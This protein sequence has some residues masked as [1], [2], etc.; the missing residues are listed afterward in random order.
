VPKVTAPSTTVTG[1]TISVFSAIQ[2]A[3]PAPSLAP[4]STARFYLSTDQTLDLG[5]DVLLGSRAVP[6]LTAGAFSN[7]SMTLTIPANTSEG[8]FFILVTADALNVV[9]E[10]NEGNNVGV[11]N[12]VTV[13]RPD[14]RVTAA[15]VTPAAVSSRGTVTVTNT[16]TNV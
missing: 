6:A 12:A 9:V 5:T 13:S 7:A 10:S 11:S 2:N 3:G 15:S 8:A 1:G 16:I 4:A 14:L